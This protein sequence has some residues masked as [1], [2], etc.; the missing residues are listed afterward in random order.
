MSL[1]PT[2][3]FS[4]VAGSYRTFRPTYPPAL[5]T[6][7]AGL[8]P[9][10][11][12]AWDC[13]TGSGQAALALADC[14]DL[15]VASD[16][17]AALL[18]DAPLHPRV[19]YAEFTA[20]SPL[21]DPTSVDLIT[22]AQAIHWFDRPRFFAAANHVMR[23]GGILAFWGYNW[24]RITPKLDTVLDDFNASVLAPHWPAESKILHEGNTSIHPPLPE[25][26]APALAMN[27]R[28]SLA[29]LLGHCA[30]WS[31]VSRAKAKLGGD[32]L[33]ALVP[34]LNAAWGDSEVRDVS[35]PLCLRLFQKPGAFRP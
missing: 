6:H 7:L 26:P 27:A 10:R 13:A 14:F 22:V 5:F 20:E 12:L 29:Q 2:D 21:L 8:A 16:Q 34:R 15:V 1:S 4:A 31:A 11:A 24:P 9:G 35:W 28:W 3:H 33:A 25:I 17:S 19:T 30:T 32:P 23:P 18:A